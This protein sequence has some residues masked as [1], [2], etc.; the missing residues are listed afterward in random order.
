VLALRI[1]RARAGLLP[2][3]LS[4]IVQSIEQAAEQSDLRLRWLQADGDPV[5]VLPIPAS[6]GEHDLRIE[7]LELR[8]GEIVVAGH[9]GPMVEAAA[10]DQS[11]P[12]ETTHR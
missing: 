4:R 9:V 1:S 12:I 3:P 6:D 10:A 8:D 7:S 11:P 5:A 2:L